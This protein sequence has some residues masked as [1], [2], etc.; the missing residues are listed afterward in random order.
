MIPNNS[1]TTRMDYTLVME[2]T[3]ARLSMIV[4]KNYIVSYINHKLVIYVYTN[5]KVEHRYSANRLK[6][7]VDITLANDNCSSF[8]TEENKVVVV[9][10]SLV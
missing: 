8:I 7:V 3:K 9:S 6:Q 1:H 10:S 2:H 5:E 4:Q